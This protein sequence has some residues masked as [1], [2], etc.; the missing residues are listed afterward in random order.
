MLSPALGHP[1]GTCPLEWVWGS[2]RPAKEPGLCSW[3]PIIPS[4]FPQTLAC[5]Q[6]KGPGSTWCIINPELSH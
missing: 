2:Q 5:Q 6:G 3:V 1:P 4:P